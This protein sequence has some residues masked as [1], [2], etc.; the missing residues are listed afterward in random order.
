MRCLLWATGVGGSWVLISSVTLPQQSHH[1]K[2]FAILLYLELQAV[3]FA[4]NS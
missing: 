1:D 3:N 4:V 2:M